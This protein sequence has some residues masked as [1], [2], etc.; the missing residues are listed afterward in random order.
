M[1]KSINERHAT[2][3]KM[4]TD[5]QFV[6][7]KDLFEV[8][9][10]SP[11][12]IRRDLTLLEQKG[13]IRKF[14]GKITLDVNRVPVF[15]T[16]HSIQNNEKAAIGRAAAELVSDNDS[17]IIDSGT[18]CLA[19]ATYLRNTNKKNVSV[20]TNSI[21]VAT[22]L[23]DTNIST[24][25]CGGTLVD[26]SLIDD[27]AVAYFSARRVNKAFIGATGVRKE[28]LTVV[29][30]LQRSVKKKMIEVATEVYALVDSTKFNT[31]G[32]NLFAGFDQLTG[33]VTYGP[34]NDKEILEQCRAHNLKI[35]D[36][37]AYLSSLINTD[38]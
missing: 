18:T 3:I 25:I 6:L 33:I 15:D 19:L 11:A 7:I 17:I 8:I 24:F 4:C 26:F 13:I 20:I 21:P 14:S 9:P 5:N 30:P 36:A 16:R 28:G 37:K 12:T 1:K 2:I 34:I 32:I 10:A 27:D 22:T 35:I 31:T 23:N 38:E 29:S